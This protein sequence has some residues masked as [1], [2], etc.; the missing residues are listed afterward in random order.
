ME[1]PR[2]NRIVLKAVATTCES[3]ETIN[4]ASEASASTQARVAFP[5]IFFIPL[6]H[7]S[8]GPRRASPPATSPRRMGSDKGF[9][10]KY[11]CPANPSAGL[12]RYVERFNARDFDAIRDMLAEEVRLE[13]VNKRRVS[14]RSELG[15]YFFNYAQLQDWMLVAGY[16]DRHPAALVCDPHDPTKTPVYFIL[17]QWAGG[18]VATIRD[19][20][21]ACYAMEG[22]ELS[23]MD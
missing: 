22:A 16:V 20:R 6:L 1:A 14:G 19:F 5:P 3:S 17:L 23:A 12:A 13:L 8:A 18:R 10:E 7:R 11:S 15:G 4:E 2:S 9:A 21:F